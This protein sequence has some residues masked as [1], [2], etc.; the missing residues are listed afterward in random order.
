M[1]F[2]V[3]WFID[4]PE[5]AVQQLHLAPIGPLVARIVCGEVFMSTGWG[6][7][8][9]LPKITQLFIDL[10]IPAPGIMAPFVSG[11]EFFGGL[12]LLVGLFTRIAAPPLVIVM[13]VAIASAKADQIDSLDTLLGFEEMSYLAMFLWLAIAGPGKL[14]LDYLFK[15]KE[16]T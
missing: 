7:L 16:Q 4:W 11:V 1:K 10:G 2:L 12:L 6:K 3:N 8:N 13:V 9:N 15:S 5:R 14:S